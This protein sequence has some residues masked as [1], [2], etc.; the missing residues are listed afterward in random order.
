MYKIMDKGD[1]AQAKADQ[2]ILALRIGCPS[3]IVTNNRGKRMR[4]AMPCRSPKFRSDWCLA[5]MLSTE[6]PSVP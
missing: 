3:L 6:G 2:Q 4:E 1:V 5:A